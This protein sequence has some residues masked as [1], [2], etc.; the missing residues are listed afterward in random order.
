[1]TGLSEL[2]STLQLAAGSD[3]GIMTNNPS[4]ELTSLYHMHVWGM[5]SMFDYGDHG[6]NK[7]ST[8]D[9]CLFYF[10][11]YFNQPMY[12][13]WQRDR[14]TAAEPWSMFWYDPGVSGAWWDGLEL[15]HYFDDDDSRWGAMRT[16]WTDNNGM[17]V[18]MKAN[19]L[20]EHQTH[21]TCLFSSSRS[22]FDP[23][24]GDLDCGDFVLDALGQRWAGELGSGDYLGD[25][26]FSSEAQDSVRWLW[27]R[28]MTEG[29][30]TLSIGGANQNVDALPVVTWG[31]TGEA[32][33]S[34]TIMELPG[35][36]TA[37]M[38]ADL[39][40]AYGQ[41]VQ[42]G[43]RFIN[44]RRQVLLQDE[45]TDVTET[46]YWRMHTNATVTIDGANANLSLG[47]KDLQV[48][49]INPPDGVSWETLDPVRTDDAPQLQ[50][51]QDPDQENPGVTV[52]SLSIPAGS[53]TIQVLFNPAWD[54]FS[55]FQT[56][57]LVPLSDWSTTSH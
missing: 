37:F 20:T 7:F 48:Q 30:N 33:A 39:T 54:D 21:G 19:R 52:L 17:Y 55:D 31:S 42:R 4:L 47:G 16:S 46:T 9:N 32:Q 34:S 15:D 29:Q 11:S 36:S 24:P 50:P 18:A 49:L 41:N 12:T 22:S 45:L 2:A 3:F 38:V 57:S 10:G 56:P 28:K 25:G 44:G 40:T 5:T 53:N 13:L 23:F 14:F 27:Y 43:I 6:P 1:M 8:T 35:S 51:G 26:Y